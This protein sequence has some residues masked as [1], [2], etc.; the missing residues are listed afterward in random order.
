MVD[1]LP[2]KKDTALAPWSIPSEAVL[3]TK[4]IDIYVEF[5]VVDVIDVGPI[6]PLPDYRSALHPPKSAVG[7]SPEQTFVPKVS[8][9]R[10]QVS[11]ELVELKRKAE[12]LQRA[13]FNN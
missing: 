12:D 11:K 4:K 3:P 6:K 7:H 1:S 5:T 2:P 8:F 13:R 10:E 9:N